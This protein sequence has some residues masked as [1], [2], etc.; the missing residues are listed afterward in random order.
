[1]TRLGKI[2]PLWQN[3]ECKFSIWQN[4]EPTFGKLSWAIGQMFIFVNGKYNL[5]IWSTHCFVRT[6]SRTRTIGRLEVDLRVVA[7]GQH[8]AD[9]VLEVGHEGWAALKIQFVM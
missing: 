4:F 7:V 3:F 2:S 1:M 9:D 5:A 6:S 8:E